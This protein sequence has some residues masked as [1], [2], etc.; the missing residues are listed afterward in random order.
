MLF[1][2]NGKIIQVQ[3]IEQATE[4]HRVTG[5][6]T[7]LAVSLA[8]LIFRYTAGLAMILLMAGCASPGPRSVYL[9]Q[10]S[11]ANVTNLTAYCTTN[12]VDID[13]PLKGRNVFAHG[14]WSPVQTNDADFQCQFAVLTFDRQKRA[15]RKSVV[16]PGNQLIVCD[17]KQW[18]QLLLGVF[19][20]MAPDKP[21]HGALLLNQQM[22]LILYRDAAGAVK[23]V[24][25]DA[26][27]PDITV[28]RTF[29]DEDFSRD[30]FKLLAARLNVVHPDQKRFLFV[31][32]GDPAFALVEPREHLIVFLAYPNDPEAT[33]MKVPGTIGLRALN[34]LV[35]KSFLLTAIKNP[36]TLISR[37]LWTLGSSGMTMVQTLPES[38]SAP[39]PPLYQGPGMDLKVWERK[40]D[41]TVSARRN[42]GQVQ[43]F[44]DGKQFFPELVQSVENARRSVDVMVYVFDTDNYATEF[45]DVLK[46]VSHS[47]RVRV[48]ADDLGSLFAKGA[49]ASAVPPNFQPP[50]DIV[51]YLEAN[52]QVHVRLSCDPW[53]AT[54]HRKCF[55]IDSH[56]AYLGGMNV[57][58]VYR[59]QWHDLMLGVTGPVVG[60]LERD[61]RKAWA[62]SGPFGD[63]GYAWALLFDHELLRRSQ[64]GDIDIRV[65]RTATAKLQIYK[66]QLAAI[67]QAKRYIYIENAYF[68]DDSILRE[69]AAARQRGVD[70]RVILPAENDVS[71]M[72]TGN[73]VMAN[74][75]IRHGIRV[76]L[77]PGMTHVK[78]AI[79]DGWA[80]V[81]SANL[82]KM[83]LRISQ[84]MD[85][86]FSDPQTVD[87]LKQELFIPDFS[88]AQELKTPLT[89]NWWDSFV[90]ALANQL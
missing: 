34:S 6:R 9:E 7:G 31:T 88:R 66:A 35:I 68:N 79:Y 1:W 46:Q 19:A 63:L 13:Y 50:G 39:P 38:S 82:E 11:P 18:K 81:G 22:E 55:I 74:E 45:A 14:R 72:Q 25:L 85:V 4:Y 15:L 86:A 47:V 64:P 54:D 44:V 30:A 16:N 10:I 87:R 43:F 75:M 51:S 78:A 80:C 37:G 49:P 32:G 21:G 76:Y 29:N 20:D 42:H 5:N 23:T 90:K 26:K 40:L 71:I 70:V 89:S 83:S 24:P 69:L 77:Y 48:L 73:R 58:W 41:R 60:R 36:V 28:D 84:E 52:S 62:F 57:G 59:Y 27:P 56:K 61:Y 53:L 33:P 8:G 12:T 67:R 65:L 3:N 17:S 2:F